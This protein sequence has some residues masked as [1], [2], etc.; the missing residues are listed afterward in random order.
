MID[1]FITNT[2]YFLS[3]AVF[4]FSLHKY[5]S[6]ESSTHSKWKNKTPAIKKASL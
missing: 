1:L 5:G 6:Q 4:K 2:F 3:E